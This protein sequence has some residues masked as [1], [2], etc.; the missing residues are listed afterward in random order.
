MKVPRLKF[1]DIVEVI[2]LDATSDS[3]WRN[4]EKVKKDA[5]AVCHSVG[6]FSSQSQTALIISPDRNSLKDRSSV[7]IPLGMLKKVRKLK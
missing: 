1:N 3:G 2:W 7:V 5:P 6:Y 4:E